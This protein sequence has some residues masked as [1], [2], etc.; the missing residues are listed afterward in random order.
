MGHGVV[1]GHDA[2]YY[3]GHLTMLLTQLVPLSDCPCDQLADSIGD[4]ARKLA[5]K[6]NVLLAWGFLV[7][8]SVG[9]RGRSCEGAHVYSMAVRAV[10]TL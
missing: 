9:C 10:V 4:E 6:Y 1:E 8:K 2:T 5:E 7:F 3:S